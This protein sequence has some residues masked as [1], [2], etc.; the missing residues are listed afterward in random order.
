MRFIQA[1]CVSFPKCSP[2]NEALRIQGIDT[3]VGCTHS[4][5]NDD[6]APHSQHSQIWDATVTAKWV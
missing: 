4:R 3:G 2:Y 5:H 1:I 6:S